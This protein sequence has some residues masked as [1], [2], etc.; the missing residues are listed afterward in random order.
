MAIF[1]ACLMGVVFILFSHSMAKI[2]TSDLVVA[3]M[4]G[5]VL[6]I[7]ALSQPGQSTQLSL[8]GALR[9][10]GDTIFPLYASFVGIWVFR[11]VVAYIFVNIF[12]WGLIGAWMALL[13]DQ[14]TRSAIVYLRFKSGKWKYARV[15]TKEV[16]AN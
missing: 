11:V 13:L 14:Y 16:H 7:M 1:V 9:G 15:K 5:T 6:K 10:A 12:N 8:A 4:A 3:A 2:Y